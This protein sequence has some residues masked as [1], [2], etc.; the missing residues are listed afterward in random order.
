MSDTL[1]SKIA[2]GEIPADI[3]YEDEDVVAFRDIGPQAPTHVL[4]IPRK[5][6][7]T[8][9]DL[10][11]DDAA[12]VGKMFLAAK[13]IAEQEGIAEA[14]YRTVMNCNAA[15]GQTV[16]HLHLHLLGGRPMQWPPG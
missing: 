9:N 5:P 1:F 2:A 3:V 12:L 8:I 15:A 7:R 16:F 14:G 11:P 6:I 10:E 13:T 4:V